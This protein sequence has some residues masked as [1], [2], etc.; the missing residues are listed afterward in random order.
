M[1]KGFIVLTG[2]GIR[3][4]REW[5]PTASKALRLVRTHM[6]LRR[7]GVRIEDERG[8]PI[9]FLELKQVAESKGGN[10]NVPRP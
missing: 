7:P 10:E 4:T 6:K 1:P 2:T 8:K 9:S 5:V 3:D